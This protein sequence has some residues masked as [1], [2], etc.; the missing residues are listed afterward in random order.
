MTKPQKMSGM[1]AFLKDALNAGELGAEES[2]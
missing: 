2:Y 1:H